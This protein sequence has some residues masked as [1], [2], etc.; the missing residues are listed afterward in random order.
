MRVF[1]ITIALDIYKALRY[2]N[3]HLKKRINLHTTVWKIN[4]KRITM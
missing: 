1:H 3:I 4:A 2:D